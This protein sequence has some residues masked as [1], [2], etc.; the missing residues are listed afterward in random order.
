MLITKFSKKNDI[1]VRRRI[2]GIVEI[3][4][5][6]MYNLKE[7]ATEQLKKLRVHTDTDEFKNLKAS[8]LLM[9]QPYAVND[10]DAVGKSYSTGGVGYVSLWLSNLDFGYRT[11]AHELGHM[12]GLHHDLQYYEKSP[13]LFLDRKA[14]G[15][16]C[17]GYGSIM[18]VTGDR[19]NKFLSSPLV[20]INGTKCGD[21]NDADSAAAYREAV[22]SGAFFAGGS[23]FTNI[24]APKS[25]KG[26]VTL[27][28]VTESI[29]ET[30]G[31]AVFDVVWEGAHE[32]DSVTL[33][34]SSDDASKDHFTPLYKRLS[35]SGDVGV[36]E[37]F[38]ID[39]FDNDVFEDDK[40]I[41]VSLIHS[42]GI[43]T[44]DQ[45]SGVITLISED[46]EPEPPVA[47]LPN[48]D[49]DKK[50]GGSL[51]WFLLFTVAIAGLRKNKKKKKK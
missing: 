15:F 37:Q 40:H 18:A 6:I 29:E 7:P 49:D 10:D 48:T 39:V 5:S 4:D 31:E 50:G 13:K 20:T 2:A 25:Q 23:P 24:V 9:I 46:I 43:S 22:N 17:D 47:P 1:Q 12:D 19:N 45:S 16:E 51:G 11:V 26:S 38:T 44:T 28:L 21:A 35:Y 3:P 14:I 36:T 30:A 42:N 41:K 33:M 34:V 8:Y 27:S 32:G